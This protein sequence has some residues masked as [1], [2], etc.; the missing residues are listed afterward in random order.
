MIDR[1]RGSPALQAFFTDAFGGTLVHDFWAPYESIVVD[2]RQY[3][4][5]HLLRELE[6]VDQHNAGDEWRSFAKRLRRLIRDGI[7]LRKRADF[8][9]E[10]Y[11]RRI[12]R[13]DAR[14]QNLAGWKDEHG[15]LLYSDADTLRLSKRLRRHW[16]HLFTFLDKPKVPFDNNLA[17]RA[18]RPAVILRKAGQSNRSEQGA[19]TQS[20]LMTVFRTLKLRGLDP[21]SSVTAGLRTYVQTGALPP[22]PQATVARG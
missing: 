22:L 17:E 13:I 20:V 19:A 12:L 14:L 6:K 10:R 3:C 1:S 7:R 8:T 4:L 5:V 2:D 11:Q 9:P 21:I 18:I 16:D 15:T